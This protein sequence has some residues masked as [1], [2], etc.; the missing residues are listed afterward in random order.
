MSRRQGSIRERAKGSYEV[1]YPLGTDPA[2]GRRRS[3]TVT[4][5]GT[6][7]DAERELRRLLRALDTGQLVD[8]SKLCVR[9]WLN[10]WLRSIRDEIAPR[11]YERYGSIVRHHIL[12]ALG[13]HRLAKL[14]PVHIQEFY[15]S[16]A[17]GGRRDGQPGALAPQTRRQ[18]HRVLSEALV[19]AV[20]QQIVARN[21]CDV[22]KRR[23]PRVERKQFAVLSTAQSQQLLSAAKP[24]PLYW[25]VLLAITTGMRRN[26]ILAVRWRNLDLGRG[27]VRIVEALEQTSDGIRFK[28]PKS[29]EPRSVTLPRF[30]VEELRRRKREQAEGLLLLGVRQ[31][32]DTLVCARSDGEGTTPLGMSNAWFKFV[33]SMPADFPRIRFHDLRH[34]HATQLLLA[35]VHANV[36]Q[37]RLGHSTVKLTMDLYSHVIPSM[38]EEA[39]AKIDLAFQTL[40]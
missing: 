34:S 4:V 14:V 2:T 5:K 30:A 21:V 32:G 37:E 39:A 22:F 15:A 7:K 24:T 31:D 16:L 1:R 8:P 29:G 11:S 38:Q 17:E 10:L 6:L 25:P 27:V 36:V 19:R 28:P 3:A 33:R 23:L 35:G 12:P 40:Q 20:E 26:E 9:D 13:N 18:I